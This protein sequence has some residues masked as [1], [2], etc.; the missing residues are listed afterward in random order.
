MK[1]EDLEAK[2]ADRASSVVQAKIKVFKTEIDD[3][4]TK[5]FGNGGRSCEQF[6]NYDYAD[7]VD[8]KQNQQFH[9]AY[10]KLYALKLAI[11]DM[12][13]SHPKT[14]IGWP[15][16]LWEREREAIRDELLSKMDLLQQLLVTKPRD[17]ED[18]VPC[19]EGTK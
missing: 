12:T 2:I 10:A 15:S 11:R 13:E 16:I 3:A 17:S 7:T 19:E 18:D 4:L 14:K 8:R 1:I 9:I 5:F 6:G